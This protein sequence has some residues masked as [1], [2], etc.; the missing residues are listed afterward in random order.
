ML[1]ANGLEQYVDVFRK[2]RIDGAYCL[3]WETMF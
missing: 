3:C 1:V 2:E